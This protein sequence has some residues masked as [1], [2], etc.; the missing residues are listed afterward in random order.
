MRPWEDELDNLAKLLNLNEAEYRRLIAPAKRNPKLRDITFRLLRLR[1]IRAGIN[2]DDIPLFSMPRDLSP[3]DYILGNAMCGEIT[4]EEVG[5]S[6]ED[7]LGGGIGIFGLS[8]VGKTT[9]VKIFLLAFSG[10]EI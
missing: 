4:G 9:L 5:L 3:S 10:K 1:L 7:L 2:P 8:G 6:Q